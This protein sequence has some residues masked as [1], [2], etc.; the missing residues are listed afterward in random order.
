[1]VQYKWA[2][3]TKYVAILEDQNNVQNLKFWENIFKKLK[4][5]YIDQRINLIQLKITTIHLV[6]GKFHVNNVI[7]YS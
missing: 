1:M 2:Y 3:K 6:L 7:L 4:F 5:Q